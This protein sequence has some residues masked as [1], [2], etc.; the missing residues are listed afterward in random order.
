MIPATSQ[1]CHVIHEPMAQN[2]MRDV[3][4]NICWT[5]VRG[6]VLRRDLHRRLRLIHGRLRGVGQLR[7]RC[8][9]PLGHPPSGKASRIPLARSFNAF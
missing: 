3:A 2:M 8:N 9:L 7:Q 4:G 1:G 5:L 6:G